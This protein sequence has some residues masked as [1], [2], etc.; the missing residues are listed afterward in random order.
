MT[1]FGW[2]GFGLYREWINFV[3]CFSIILGWNG[4]RGGVLPPSPLIVSPQSPPD[5]HIVILNFPE[6]RCSPLDAP[7]SVSPVFPPHRPSLP[8]QQDHYC[9]LTLSPICPPWP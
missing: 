5:H 4:L 9:S 6:V 2:F 3:C 8:H 7:G 1:A